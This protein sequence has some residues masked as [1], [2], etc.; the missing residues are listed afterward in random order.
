[1]TFPTKCGEFLNRLVQ[2]NE[3]KVSPL[4]SELKS[5]HLKIKGK[6]QSLS[7]NVQD[8]TNLTTDLTKFQQSYHS[9]ILE[10]ERRRNVQTKMIQILEE[11]QAKI[12]GLQQD[13]FRFRESFWSKNG[14]FLPR[15][16]YSEERESKPLTEITLKYTEMPKFNDHTITN[17]RK[18][19]HQ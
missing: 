1:M 15:E 3:D 4:L 13:D 5:M 14:D 6:L 11:A 2:F 12:Q 19:L 10:L 8:A 17:A 9:L 16:L 18:F 7:N